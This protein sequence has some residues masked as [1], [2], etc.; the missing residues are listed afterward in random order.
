[1]IQWR[2]VVR[3]TEIR[4]CRPGLT[5]LHIIDS[6]GDRALGLGETAEALGLHRLRLPIWDRDGVDGVDGVPG[7]AGRRALGKRGLRLSVGWGARMVGRG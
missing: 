3:R 1:M 5:P 7:R 2:R 4:Q 6:P